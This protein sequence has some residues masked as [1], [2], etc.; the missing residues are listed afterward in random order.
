MLFNK[1]KVIVL[2]TGFCVISVLGAI[3]KAYVGSHDDSMVTRTC[4]FK[5]IKGHV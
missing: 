1:L 5:Y 3:C 2:C 4:V